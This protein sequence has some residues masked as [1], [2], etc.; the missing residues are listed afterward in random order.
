MKR[1]VV[2]KTADPFAERVSPQ[3]ATLVSA[4]PTR[5]EWVYEIKLDGYRILARCEGGKARLFTRSG[6][7]RTSKME[8]LAREIA[9]LPVQTAWLD[10]EAV[11]LSS[12]GRESEQH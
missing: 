8:S 4:P 2:K 12:I 6:N 1:T 11:V 7:D 10:G 9:T 3:L 5:G